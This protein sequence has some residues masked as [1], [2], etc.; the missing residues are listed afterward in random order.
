VIGY[1]AGIVSYSDMYS[2]MKRAAIV[3]LDSSDANDFLRR[4]R[5]E[6][7]L[8]LVSE[9]D[10]IRKG[11]EILTRLSLAD[12]TLLR[13]LAG[14]DTALGKQVNL[15]IV[16]R[17][18]RL[19]REFM[20]ELFARQHAAFIDRIRNSDVLAFIHLKAI[21][22]DTIQRWTDYIKK[23][24][25]REYLRIL[26][27]SGFGALKGSDL[28]ISMPFIDPALIRHLEMLGYADIVAAMCGRSVL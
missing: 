8:G 4:V 20:Q 27:R 11:A 10:R 6:N 3:Y 17:R 24:L 22:S 19:F 18:D 1:S 7:A 23:R 13:W 14:D 26:E 9:R 2:T 12:P 25:C 15:F 28:V 16:M 5:D 21:S